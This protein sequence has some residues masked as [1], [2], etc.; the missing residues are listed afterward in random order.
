MYTIFRETHMYID[1]I[2][3]YIRHIWYMC[4]NLIY[5]Y[6]LYTP[7]CPSRGE[8]PNILKLARGKAFVE[9]VAMRRLACV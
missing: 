7:N 1:M 8:I 6:I 3:M 4:D 5:I 2:Y 9:V